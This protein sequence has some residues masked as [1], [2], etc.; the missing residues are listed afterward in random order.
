MTPN[1]V[2]DIL[3]ESPVLLLRDGHRYHVDRID[4]DVSKAESEDRISATFH[5]RDTEDLK[6]YGMP[7]QISTRF[8]MDL[9]QWNQHRTEM[10][11]MAFVI[12]VTKNPD[13]SAEISWDVM[14]LR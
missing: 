3:R 8:F 10:P 1:M 13:G 6:P 11:G 9:D 2:N 14:G 4:F 7:L 5:V 12:E